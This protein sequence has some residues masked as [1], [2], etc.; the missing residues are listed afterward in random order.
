MVFVFEIN[1]EIL[2][3]LNVALN[4][5]DKEQRWSFTGTHAGQKAPSSQSAASCYKV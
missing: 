4:G 5:S 1:N 3:L 2:N